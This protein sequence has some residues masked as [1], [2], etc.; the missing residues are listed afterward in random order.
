M[1]LLSGVVAVALLLG[2]AA[3]TGEPIVLSDEPGVNSQPS[4]ETQAIGQFVGREKGVHGEEETRV[5]ISRGAAD[6]ADIAFSFSAKK[7]KKEKHKKKKKHRKDKSHKKH[8]KQKNERKDQQP[9]MNEDEPTTNQGDPTAHLSEL[10]K[11]YGE[12]KTIYL[13]SHSKTE[14]YKLKYDTMNAALKE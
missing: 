8:K 12:Q 9:M 14:F 13:K 1:R 11:T 5:E 4:F 6:T 2:C 7:Q 3:K 10:K